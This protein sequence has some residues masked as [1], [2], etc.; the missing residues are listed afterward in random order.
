MNSKHQAYPT[1]QKTAQETPAPILPIV[2][3]AAVTIHLKYPLSQ[4]AFAASNTGVVV[5]TVNNNTI[6]VRANNSFQL[7]LFALRIFI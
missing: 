1:E 2:S 4:S 3:N 6:K 5:I 7:F